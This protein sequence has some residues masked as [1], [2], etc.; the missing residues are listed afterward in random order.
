M[1]SVGDFVTVTSCVG[2]YKVNHI[3]KHGH[4]YLIGMEGQSMH[5]CKMTN[6]K[7]LKN[8]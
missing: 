8:S 3:N 1:F 5:I 7:I 6:L 4:V 2:I